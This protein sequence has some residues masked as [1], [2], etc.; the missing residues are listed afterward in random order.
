M[1][2]VN[3]EDIERILTDYGIRAKILHCEELQ[4]YYYEKNDPDSKEVRLITRVDLGDKTSFVMRFKNEKD[5]TQELIETQSRFAEILHNTGISTPKQ[6]KVDGIFAKR[7]IIGGYDVIVTIEQFAEN[8]V[9]LVDEE[10][11]EKTGKLLAQMHTISE[12][13]DLHIANHVLFDPFVRNE[14]FDFD[15]FFSLKSAVEGEE[16]LLFDKIVNTYHTY[17]DILAD[18][19]QQTRY[20]VQGDISNCNLYLAPSDEIGI[21]DFNRAGDNILF[22]DA[23]M[24]A[25]FEAKLM[26]YPQNDMSDFESLVLNAFLK[27]YCSVR[28]F[29]EKEKRW[30]PYLYAIIS[31]FWSADIRWSE[32]SLLKAHDAGDIAS[33]RRWM[34]VILERILAIESY[35]KVIRDL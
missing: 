30:Y 11:A 3:G 10:I 21:F 27:G 4:R 24:Q 20:A 5:V 13:R 14:L 22:C 2:E 26:D 31:A 18:L 6:Y 19:K 23:V 25:V 34:K 12:Q 16:K 33:I 9:Q 1:F 29:T 32:D 8:E 15:A 17:M 7:Y 35:S 28:P